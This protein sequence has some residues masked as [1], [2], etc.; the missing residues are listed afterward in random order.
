MNY[1]DIEVQADR[2]QEEQK[3]LEQIVDELIKSEEEI[4]IFVD[5]DDVVEEEDNLPI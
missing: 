3:I 1:L 5:F 4:N 2:Y